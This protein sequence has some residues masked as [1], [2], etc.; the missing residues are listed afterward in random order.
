MKQ[1]N[2]AKP[3]A[4]QPDKME[5]YAD[6]QDRNQAAFLV[7]LARLRARL[8]ALAEGNVP[9]ETFPQIQEDTALSALCRAF[10]LRPFERDLL[11]L[12]AGVEM[13]GSF[14][15]LCAALHKNPSQNYAT[16]SMALKCLPD[17]C[18]S[19]ITPTAPLRR[20][21][22]IELAGE[23]SAIPLTVAPLRVDE[24]ILHYLAGALYPDPRI[25]GT[26]LPLGP[27]D[28]IAIPEPLGNGRFL[29]APDLV[30]ETH[31][32][33]AAEI[34]QYW[35]ACYARGE[36]PTLI[37]LCGDA[38]QDKTEVAL[39]TAR[40]LRLRLR[41]LSTRDFPRQPAEQE[42][43]RVLWE[44]EARLMPVAFF[45][46]TE[47]HPEPL[48]AEG[49]EGGATGSA[50]SPSNAAFLERLAGPIFLA[51]GNRLPLERAAL[52]RDIEK[53]QASEQGA[54][55]KRALEQGEFSV[56][57]QQWEGSGV[58]ERITGQF[59]LSAGQIVMA[60][61]EACASQ[62]SPSGSDPNVCWQICRRQARP[63]METLAQRI[64]A[65]ADWDALI[66]PASQK[67]MLW[68]LMAQ[69]R[70][71]ARVYTAWKMDSGAMGITALFSG[72]SGTGKTLAAEVIARELELDLYRV[73]LAA[74]VSKYI[75][76]TEKNLRRLFAAAESGGSILLFDEADSLFGKRSE[77]K[78]SHDRH[79]NIEVSYLL[80]RME[81]YRGLAILTTNLKSALDVAFYR[82]LRF[83][84]E[85]PFPD[86]AL[87]AA[88][89]SGVF[90]AGVTEDL[91]I[92]RLG[93]LNF[94]GGSIRNCALNAAFLAV[95]RDEPV[96]MGHILQAARA[97]CAKMERAL[98]ET[99]TQ[100]WPADALASAA[101]KTFSSS[102]RKKI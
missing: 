56:D 30:S 8:E 100:D 80:Q 53:P 49:D 59:H 98:T 64:E 40:L 11:L 43:L 73:D 24:W 2:E 1:K 31:T 95:E 38:R 42:T 52:V 89:W 16:F 97:E 32:Q 22:L 3:T 9:A 12:C 35:T 50:I 72:P 90:P 55:W 27:G 37:Q 92:E 41:F 82:R 33:A 61:R 101:A 84:V 86:A 54:L 88:L 60:A 5:T 79:A 21:R 74:V 14:A 19:A 78:D 18:W 45:V 69:A 68:N 48:A 46:E 28:P 93:Q 20:H 62:T 23:G 6:W 81:S 34:A 91:D 76:E 51:V 102:R 96:R 44:R 13:D 26:T 87:R 77:V 75:G 29:A 15:P 71:R 63:D 10:S 7:E 39:H 66:L 85:F 67:E 99:E 47:F 70:N 57:S 94:A 83:V 65:K 25:P 58:I 17:A 4:A 36:A